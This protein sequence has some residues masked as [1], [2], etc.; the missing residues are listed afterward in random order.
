MTIQRC[1]LQDNW[2]K[3]DLFA[4]ATRFNHLSNLVDVATN[5]NAREARRG[6][7]LRLIEAV[8]EVAPDDASVQCPPKDANFYKGSPCHK[9]I[10]FE[11]DGQL[12]HIDRMYASKGGPGRSYTEFRVFVNGKFA[13]RGG[14]AGTSLGGGGSD[15]PAVALVSNDK[16]L[17]VSEDGIALWERLD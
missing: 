16:M 1:P 6:K 15:L 11:L 5:Q 13:G 10:E 8:W 17:T 9:H 3:W 4:E 12:V 7:R 2:R 14:G